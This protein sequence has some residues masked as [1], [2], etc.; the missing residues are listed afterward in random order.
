M[1]AIIGFTSPR[2]KKEQVLPY[3]EKTK[4]RG[5]D[6]TRMEP[7]GSGLLGF[8]RL[9]IMGLH[10]EGMQ[11]FHLG[12][13]MAVCNGELYGFRPVKA[14]LEAKGYQFQSD[15]DCE[16]ILPLWKE[17]GT[18][19]FAKLDAEFAMIIYDAAS[20]SCSMDISKTARS[21]SPVR[22]KTS[23][24]SAPTSSPSRRAITT[25]PANSSATRT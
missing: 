10:P 9:A 20:D 23:S 22:R 11:P 3:F 25:R 8:H 17:Y 13:D 15:S 19:M 7:A 4:S 14:M 5:P 18:D 16:I 24:A 12:R 21:S 1:C 6:D 2:L